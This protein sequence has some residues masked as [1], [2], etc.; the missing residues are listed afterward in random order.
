M[1][2][3]Y[4]V[5]WA[6]NFEQTEHEFTKWLTIF[7]NSSTD[8]F[9]KWTETKSVLWLIAS[10]SAANQN[11]DKVIRDQLIED[12]QKISVDDLAFESVMYY[13]S[14]LQI[15]CGQKEDAL[16]TLGIQPTFP[17]TGFGYIEFDK[18]DEN[19][20]KKVNQFREKPDYHTAKQFLKEG[21]FLWNAGIFI[22]S[23]ESII[24][25]FKKN[26]FNCD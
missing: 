16:M 14:V 26:F 2:N 24:N 19:P 6:N 22:W 15:K 7:R 12:A 13:A 4:Y 11:T 9:E 1:E 21:N 20:I 10:L 23:V 3:L 8:V 25:S 17:N 5:L 18:S